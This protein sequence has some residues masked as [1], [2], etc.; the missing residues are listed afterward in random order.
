MPSKNKPW[1]DHEM[2]YAQFCEAQRILERTT[3]EKKKKDIQLILTHAIVTNPFIPTS[4][5]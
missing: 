1:T 4:N 3:D 5:A 2:S